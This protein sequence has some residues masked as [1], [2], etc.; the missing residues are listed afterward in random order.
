MGSKVQIV[1]RGEFLQ[2]EEDRESSEKYAIQ[3]FRKK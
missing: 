2:A 1:T 3:T